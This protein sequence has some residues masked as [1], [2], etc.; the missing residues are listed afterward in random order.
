M[1]FQLFLNLADNAIKYTQNN[2]IIEI[3]L[4]KDDNHAVFS[5]KDNGIGIPEESLPHIFERFYRVDKS[6]SRQSG[7]YGLGLAVCKTI[8]EAHKGSISIVSN[9][10][11]GTKVVVRLPL[12]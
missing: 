5:I 6:R 12:S 9:F 4:V 8:V 10:S 11:K 2:G 1:I 7:G 3:E